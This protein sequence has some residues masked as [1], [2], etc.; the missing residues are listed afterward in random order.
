MSFAY[1]AAAQENYSVDTDIKILSSQNIG[2]TQIVLG[3]TF[4]IPLGK[5]FQLSNT[6]AYK[7]LDIDYRKEYISWNNSMAQFNSIQNA[8]K[9]SYFIS[10]R[11]TLSVQAEPAAN[12]QNTLGTKDISLFGSLEMNYTI[13]TNNRLSIGVGRANT[14]GKEQFLPLFSYYHQFKP[15]TSINIGFPESKISYALNPSSLFRIANNFNGSFYN[16]DEHPLINNSSAER[17]SF[18]QMSTSLEYQ[19]S[20]DKN[21]LVTFK[22]GYDFNRRY[23]ILNNNS[24]AIYGFSMSNG[25]NFSIAIKYKL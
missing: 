7:N 5:K 21:W 17:A 18:S 4:D 11:T 1:N 12:F 10:A 6:L 15:G 14:F 25:T 19:R 22:G 24:D 16:L 9:L 20:I 13:N 3:G 8:L 23:E 2:L